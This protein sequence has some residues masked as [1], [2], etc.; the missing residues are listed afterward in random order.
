MFGLSV[1]AELIFADI[2]VGVFVEDGWLEVLKD[3]CYDWGGIPAN[4]EE[5]YWVES[6]V[7]CGEVTKVEKQPSNWT[8]IK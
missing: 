6:P 4:C 7:N 2:G 5:Q 8:V 1:F 3:P